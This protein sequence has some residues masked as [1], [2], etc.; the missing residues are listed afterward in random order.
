MNIGQLNQICVVITLF[1]LI[2]YQTELRLVPN[3]TGN[4]NQNPQIRLDLTT[5]KTNS[6]ANCSEKF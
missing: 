2:W 4:C 6:A 3:Q 1:Q 5:L